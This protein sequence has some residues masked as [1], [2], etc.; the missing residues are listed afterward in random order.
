MGPDSV[1]RVPSTYA[2]F[3]RSEGVQ[4]LSEMKGY[5]KV[6]VWQDTYILTLLLDTVSS[7]TTALYEI[8]RILKYLPQ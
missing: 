2:D 1:R 6:P 7:G 4:H 5:S 8:R 3:S